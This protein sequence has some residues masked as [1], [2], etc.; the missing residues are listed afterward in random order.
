MAEPS[1][2]CT[3]PARRRAA[4]LS[5]TELAQRAGVS[6]QSLTAIEAGRSTP[7]TAL[8]LRLAR[9]L[10]CAVEDLFQLGQERLVGLRVAEPAGS[11]VALGRV[12]GRWVAHPLD[13]TDGVAGDGIV[14]ARG[15]V[16]ALGDLAR[17]EQTALLAGCAPALGVLAERLGHR[18]G[19]RARWLYAGSTTALSW[20]A[21]GRV[22]V[23]GVH[24]ADRDR[25]DEH[26]AVVRR[27]LGG[28]PVQVI[29]LL[30]WREGL[31]TAPGNPLGVHS[32]GDLA[33]SGLRLARRATGSGAARVL[34]RALATAGLGHTS[35]DGPLATSHVDTARA[36]RL[37]AADTG[38]VI[39]P[40]AQ[41][42]GLPFVPL[43]EER[44]E[45]V[46]GVEH[47]HHP[48]V[49]ALLDTLATASFGRE[50]RGMGAYDLDDLG[51]GRRVEAA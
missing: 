21:E 39:E 30:A 29:P 47:L 7:S 42:F 19:P 34:R 4:G 27:V 1:V 11:R 20:L 5:V 33:R 50:L 18:R 43:S 31:V 51:T 46:V 49:A 40:V 45:L 28:R 23:A 13:G 36:I 38:V 26:D 41:A 15:G 14:D 9:A 17:L 10:G 6:R 24:L 22:H 8:A 37:G 16:D 48:G 44:F 12:S 35:I 3:V 25:P 2:R 32:P